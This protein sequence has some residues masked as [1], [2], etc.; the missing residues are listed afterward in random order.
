[1]LTV[2]TSILATT[3]LAQAP[4]SIFV[5]GVVVDAAGKPLSGVD[6]VLPARRPPDGSLPTLAHTMTDEKGAFRLEI[7]RQ[8]FQDIGLLPFVWAYSPGR[9]VAVQE[10]VIT[11]KAAMPPV[12]LTLAEPLPRTVTILGP[13]GR[14][15]AGVRVAPVSYASDGGPR[16][17]QTPDDRLERLTIT[18]GAD[19]VATLPYFPTMLDPFT[20]RVTAPGIA[21]HRLGLP[22]RP[23]RDRITLKLGRPTRLAGSVYNDSGQPASNVPIEVWVSNTYD[24]PWGRGETRKATLPASLIHFD[25]G[26]VRTGADGSFLT[27][28]QLLTGSSYRIIIRSEGN[29]LVTSDW[30]T[31]TTELTTVPPLRLQQRR[32]LLGLVHDRQG[33]PVA[34]AQ[35]FLPSGTPSTTTDAQGR[36]LLHGV[37]PDKT[38]LLVKAEG[39]RFQGWP[40]VPAREPQERELILVRT[41]EPP[42]RTMAPL[43]APISFEE[44]RAL[45]RRVLEPALQAALA[46][47]DLRSKFACLRIASRIDPGRVL[48]LL[49]QHPLGDPGA[50]AA[51]R[52]TVATELLSADPKEAESIVNA[53]ASPMS[54]AWAYVRLAEAL[55]DQE[56][57]RKRG[58]LELA[59][60]QVRPPGSGGDEGDRHNRLAKLGQVAEGWLNV[61]EVDKARPLIREGLELFA[62][63]TEPERYHVRFLATAARIEPDRVLS[64]I[65]D[66]S[67]AGRRRSCYAAVAESLANEH[68]AEA[69]RVFQLIIDESSRVSGENRN[70]IAL[71]LCWRLAKTDPERARRIITGLKTPQDQACGW[72]VL[73]LG[74]ADRAKPAARSALAESIQVIDRLL[75]SAGPVKPTTLG[76]MVAN[77]PAASILPIVEKVA[78]ERLEEV[79]WRAVA[80]M[81]KGNMARQQQGSVDYQVVIAAISL[82]RYDR[83]VADVFVTQAMSSQSRS[84]IF[85]SPQVIRAKAGV[86]PQAAVAMMEALPQAGLDPQVPMNALT[87]EARLELAIYLV[88]PGEYHWK[89][90][91]SLLGVSLHEREFP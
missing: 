24:V 19:G 71:R 91:W 6:V 28:A 20:V 52:T 70:Q 38:F 61:G 62:A 85:Y 84:R 51:I 65:R 40:G 54:R 60:V 47:G 33:K 88:E 75:D 1:M 58:F 25:S 39:F 49:E 50:E 48:D 43:P 78:P 83:Q 3:L 53:I 26:P 27:P 18:S 57:A 41:S 89:Y 29:P 64:L 32:K 76:M 44:S 10:A 13:D 9:S 45:A 35:V 87:N 11:E 69:E 12:R 31:A 72:A 73:A 90:V 63:L 68:P 8:R 36:Y 59:T 82:A 67:S 46:K 34:G 42:D 74:L 23:G 77:D 4:D 17:Y 79:F 14:P 66:L 21:L 30:V 56:R 86:D 22:D 2:M 7:T 16:T 81:P 15:L 80:L 55:P 5:S 37:L